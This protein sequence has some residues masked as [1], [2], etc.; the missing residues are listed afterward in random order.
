MREGVG[1]GTVIDNGF[2]FDQGEAFFIDLGEQVFGNDVASVL[3]NS[4]IREFNVVNECVEW[5]GWVVS[6]IGTEVWPK[7]PLRDFR[8]LH[9]AVVR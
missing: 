1:G 9:G 2:Q 4:S 7:S 5:Q 6:T 8:R 3:L